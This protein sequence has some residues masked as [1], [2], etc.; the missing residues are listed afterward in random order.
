[1]CSDFKPR[2]MGRHDVPAS[3]VRNA[4]AAEMAMKIRSGLLVSR[5]IV[6]RH[7]PPAPGAQR[8]RAF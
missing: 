3:S 4:P 1:M 6:C 5:R 8:S 2:L 7:N